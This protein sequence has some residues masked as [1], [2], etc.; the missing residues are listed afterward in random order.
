MKNRKNENGFTLIEIML[1]VTIIGILATVVL[2]RL[3]GR[4]EEARISAAK[5]QIENI[6]VAADTFELD[7]GRFPSTQEGLDALYDKPAGVDNWKGPY[8]K[9]RIVKDPWGQQ[10]VYVCPGIHNKD[11]DLKSYGQNKADG[12]GDDIT[13]W[14]ENR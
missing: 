11:F 5:L 4:S 13:N 14:D 2:P 1:V 9:K 6:G 8:L 7:T 10:Y 12:G 3:I